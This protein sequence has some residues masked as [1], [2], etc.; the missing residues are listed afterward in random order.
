MRD[1]VVL[2]GVLSWY[3]APP[4]QFPWREKAFWHPSSKTNR[5]VNSMATTVVSQL[6]TS[7]GVK[8]KAA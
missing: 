7:T 8:P 1:T 5:H 4:L 6:H 3:T 2:G